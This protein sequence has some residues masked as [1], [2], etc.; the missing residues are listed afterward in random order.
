MVRSTPGPRVVLLTG[1]LGGARLAPQLRNTL[2]SGR[3]S[4]VANVGDDIAW[5]GLRVCPDLDSV[6]YALAGL[7]DFERGWG[8]RNET[9]RVR[10]ALADLHER[11]WFNVGDRDLAFHLLRADYLRSGRSLTDATRELSRRLGITDVEVLPAS[12]KPS[13]TRVLLKDS[14]LLHFQEWYVGERADPE[15]REV[16]PAGGAASN[17][18]VRAIE[19]ADAVIL[20]PSNPIT[21]I[22]AILALD[23]IGDAIRRTP[24]CIAVSPVVAGIESDDA[25]VRHHALARQ[26]AL[27][28]IGHA[29]TPGAIAGLY[30][31]I[32]ELFL[33]DNADAGDAEEVRR[34]GLKPV[35]AD[36]LDSKALAQMLA[37]LVY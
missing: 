8:L 5:H 35:C 4:V 28:T 37:T 3:F 34:A 20:G 25:G 32:A 36:L 31:D 7:W 19:N 9:F 17:V 12:D 23:G 13:E 22:G 30:T 14:R 16:R 26:R 6:T 1:G 27:A 18:A 2:G 21:S 10:D 29:D 15:L 11:A 33:I 24:R